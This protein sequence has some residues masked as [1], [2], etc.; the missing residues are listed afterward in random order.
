MDTGK[1]KLFCEKVVNGETILIN[2]T[3]PAGNQGL[4]VRSIAGAGNAF[5]MWASVP[6][7]QVVGCNFTDAPIC[8]ADPV[9][10]NALIA[11]ITATPEEKL[12]Y[13]T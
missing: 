1:M 10:N 2:A 12:T 8:T 7:G 13:A 11:A 5:W 6:A 4:F 9:V 3:T